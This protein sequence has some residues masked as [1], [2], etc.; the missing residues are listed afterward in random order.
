MLTSAPVPK[1]AYLEGSFGVCMDTCKQRV[2]GVL[3]QYGHVI[4]YESR[5]L[6]EHEHNYAIHDLELATIIHA[7]KM[8]RH[9]LMGKNFELINDHDGLK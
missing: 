4:N 8:W 7:L 6:K 9:Y 3:M 1:I 5:K 2:S